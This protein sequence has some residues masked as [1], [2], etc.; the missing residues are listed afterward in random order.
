MA[1]AVQVI[2]QAVLAVGIKE[3]KC[4]RTAKTDQTLLFP[5]L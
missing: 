5:R 3:I 1:V 4:Q 2:V